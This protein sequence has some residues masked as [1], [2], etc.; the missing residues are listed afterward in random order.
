[1]GMLVWL[2]HGSSL[3]LMWLVR[4]AEPLPKPSGI[5]WYSL[6]AVSGAP[7]D[8]TP[9]R[10]VHAATLLAASRCAWYQDS[11]RSAVR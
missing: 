2:G 4:G 1:M 6:R 10:G 7:C 9:P 8:L 5:R 3:S 11:Y